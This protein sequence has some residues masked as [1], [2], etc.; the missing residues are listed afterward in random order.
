[1]KYSEPEPTLA[2]SWSLLSPSVTLVRQY[3][4]PLLYVFILPALLEALGSTLA[5]DFKSHDTRMAVGMTLIAI[6]GLWSLGSFAAFYYVL[7]HATKDHPVNPWEAYRNS[8]RR[9]LPNIGLILLYGLLVAAGLLLL[10]VPGLIILRRYYLAPYYLNDQKLSIREAMRRSARD[11]KPV[12]G[13]IWGIIGVNFVFVVLGSMLNLALGGI[14]VIA[15]TL[16]SCLYIF[17][18][19]LRYREITQLKHT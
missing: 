5:G 10:I 8:A 15:T 9:I 19:A 11:T 1:M 4:V 14:G 16:L 2:S 17:A 12:S 13:Y 3:F 18:P 6:S 7:L